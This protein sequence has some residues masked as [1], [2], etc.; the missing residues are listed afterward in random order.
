MNKFCFSA[1]IGGTTIKMGIFTINGDLIDKWEIKT[2]KS[3]KGKHILNDIVKIIDKK[4]QEKSISKNDILGLGVGVPGPVDENG[5]VDG[6][7][8]LGWTKTNIKKEL[9]NLMKINIAVANDANVAALGEMWKGGGEGYNSIVMVTLGTGVGGGII[10][11][12]KIIAGNIGAAGEI[13]HI[14]VNRNE[15]DNC[16]CGKKGCLEQYASAT[17]IVKIAKKFLKDYNTDSEL[18]NLNN[19][20]AKDVLDYA[21]KGDKLSNDI[22]NCIC[23]YLGFS[24]ANISCVIDPEAFVIGG[25]VSRAGNFLIEKISHFYNK[26]AFYP[27]KNKIFCIAKLENDAGI[28]G[29][30]KMVLG[31]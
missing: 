19:I 12:G 7:V 1:D 8:N 27:C 24:L 22:I 30:A 31:K 6:C 28:Y 3:E 14:T 26:Y 13:G 17:G 16:N 25:G 10:S 15:I 5:F 29:C 11:K 20:S 2:D 18:R 9:E 4:C 23:D 21:K